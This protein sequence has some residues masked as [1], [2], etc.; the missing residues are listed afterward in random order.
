MKV[1]IFALLFQ[2]NLV[3]LLSGCNL[4][5]GVL[6]YRKTPEFSED[7]LSYK[8]V[9]STQEIAELSGLNDSQIRDLLRLQSEDSHRGKFK[10]ILPTYVP[11]GFEVTDF[12]IRDWKHDRYTVA[13]DVVIT[14]SNPSQV[15]FDIFMQLEGAGGSPMALENIDVFSPAL[16]NV[17]AE[18]TEFSTESETSYMTVEMWHGVIDSKYVYSVNSSSANEYTKCNLINR[19]E[20]INIVESLHYLSP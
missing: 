5:E 17:V 14:Y 8:Q 10:A 11:S 12:A 6:N 20:F 9:Y 3:W 18:I 15:C 2:L 1:K 19:R 7:N 16:G 13:Y 4:I